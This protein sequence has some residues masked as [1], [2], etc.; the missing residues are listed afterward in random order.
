M[1]MMTKAV[2]VKLKVVAGV[3]S[4]EG[5][6]CVCV[7]C[8]CGLCCQSTGLRSVNILPS[9]QNWVQSTKHHTEHVL[10]LGDMQ[11]SLSV[12]VPDTVLHSSVDRYY[13]CLLETHLQLQSLTSH[14]QCL[15][16]LT[17]Q[18]YDWTVRLSIKT[19]ALLFLKMLF[20]QSSLVFCRHIQT[21][22]SLQ[23]AE[24]F[25]FWTSTCNPNLWQRWRCFF[26]FCFF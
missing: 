4:T 3:C 22:L 15:W 1:M 14:S 6:V 10:L 17:L 24:H 18:A 19:I 20:F 26:V 9:A 5:S 25:F 16:R 2:Y 23:L 13:I 12:W 7:C 8:N 21:S 11:Y